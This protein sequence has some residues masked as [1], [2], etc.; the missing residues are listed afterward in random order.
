MNQ[1]GEDSNIQIRSCPRCSVVQRTQVRRTTEYATEQQ[2]P[3]PFRVSSAFM[4][5]LPSQR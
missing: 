5:T 2:D 3:E 1:Q 4:M